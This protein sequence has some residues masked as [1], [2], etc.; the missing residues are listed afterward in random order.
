MVP[1]QDENRLTSRNRLKAAAERRGLTLTFFRTIGNTVRF[2]VGDQ[3][4]KSAAKP[5]EPAPTIVSSE[6][7]PKKRGGRPRKQP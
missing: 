1:D 6:A 7:P 5:A 4:N 3:N 2:K